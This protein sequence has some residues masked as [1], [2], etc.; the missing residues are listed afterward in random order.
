MAGLLHNLVDVPHLEVVF[1]EGITEALPVNLGNLNL[2]PSL[3]LLSMPILVTAMGYGGR[4]DQ[5]RL[6]RE[7]PWNRFL[8]VKVWGGG[9]MNCRGVRVRS[10]MV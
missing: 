3:R 10:R 5:S 9:V 2:T 7:M 6:R 8:L 1:E 4:L